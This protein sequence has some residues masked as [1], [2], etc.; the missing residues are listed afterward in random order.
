MSGGAFALR[1]IW[2]VAR[3]ELYSYVVSPMAYVVATV[4]LLVTGV[5]FYSMMASQITS[6]TLEPL[7]PSIVFLLGLVVPIFTMRL[8]AE[9]KATGTV[10]LLMTFPLTDTHVVLGKYLA[11]FI[12]YAAMLVPTL[13]FP[14][15][16]RAYGA[17]DVGPLATAYLGLLLI[18]GAF[19]AVGMF[20][21]SLARSQIIAAVVGVGLLLM[22]WIIGFV[23]QSL[24]PV[25]GSAASR[26]LGYLS[27]VDHFEDF[28]RG[29][30]QTGDVVFYLTFIFTALFL[31]VQTLQS[32]RWRG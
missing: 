7:L 8:V 11:A 31:T 9:E 3:K 6:A 5:I 10:E 22:F 13:V 21:S 26:G 24:A 16:L 29:V 28:G 32:S 20:A 4:F 2:A 19:L 27:L 14:A 15:V 17:T 23:S 30:L 18:G 12:T 25:F 1:A